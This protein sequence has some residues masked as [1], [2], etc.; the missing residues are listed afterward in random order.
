M[1]ASY[2]AGPRFI[3][4]HFSLTFPSITSEIVTSLHDNPFTVAVGNISFF[5]LFCT[6]YLSVH[7]GIYE[8][9]RS[10][11]AGSAHTVRYAYIR[12]VFVSVDDN[13]DDNDDR[14]Y[15]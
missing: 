6:T 12:I 9:I 4:V 2:F 14:S 7:T 13:V 15:R 11:A 3:R 10:Q 8:S 5:F 1:I